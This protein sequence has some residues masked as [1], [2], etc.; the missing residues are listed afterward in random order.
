M[1]DPIANERL[2]AYIDGELDDATVAEVERALREDPALRAAHDELLAAVDFVRE[3]GPADAPRG[4]HARVMNHVGGMPLPIPWWRRLL[5]PF[6]AVPVESLAVLAAAALVIYVIA[7]PDPA[8]TPPEVAHSV[9][10]AP[11][12]VEAPAPALKPAAPVAPETPPQIATDDA[13]AQRTP[14]TPAERREVLDELLGTR[15]S[16]MSEDGVA[17]V[18]PSTAPPAEEGSAQV[19]EGVASGLS[20]SVA[21]RLSAENPRALY[22]LAALAGRYGGSLVD[23]GTGEPVSARRL[24]ST[25]SRVSVRVQV[26]AG[27]IEEFTRAAAAIGRVTTTSSKDNQLYGGGLMELQVDLVYTGE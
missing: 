10:E 26:P 6:R 14:P 3:H 16:E 17:L 5:R 8:P 1:T 24:S 20:A 21:Y 11:A 23:A 22:D 25:D 12:P 18:D 15:A 4:F 9:A 7:T 27:R 19:S 2:S 13:V